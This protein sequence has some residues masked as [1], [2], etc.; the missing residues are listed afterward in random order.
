MERT[1]AWTLALVAGTLGVALG[2]APATPTYT[3]IDAKIARVQQAWAAP[4]ATPDPNAPGWNGLFDV[5]RKELVAYTNAKTE[6]DGL[7]ALGRL[8]QIS[9][10]LNATAWAPAAEIRNELRAWLRPRVALAW[11]SRQLV[12]SVNGLPAASDAGAQGNRERWVQFVGSDLGNALRDYE[13]ASEV[14]NRRAALGR[15]QAA[16]N[17]LQANNQSSPWGPSIQLQTALN[18]LFNA[19][20]LQATADAAVVSPRLANYVV[21]SG[22][23]TRNGQTAY[24]TAGPFLGFGLMASDDGIMFYNRQALSSVTPINGFQQQV[25]RDP[26]GQRAAK[27]YQ[28]GATST[29]QSVLTVIAVLRPSGIQLFPQSTHNTNA[30]VGSSP[31]PGKGFPR[32]IASLIG[33]N[34]YKITQK[35]HEGAIG[36]IRQQVDQG[37]REEA[38]ERTAVR[39]AQTNAQ[40]RNVFVGPNTLAVKDFEVDALRLRSRPE[41]VIVDGL[42]KWRGGPNQ[43]GA[44]SPRPSQFLAAN[45]G[46]STDV[47]LPSVATNLAAGYFTTPQ[48]QGVTNVMVQTKDVPP[49]TPPAQ[50]AQVTQ[51]ADFPTFSKAVQDAQAANNPKVQALRLR[52]PGRAPEFSSDRDGNL[53]ALVY[54]FALEVPAPP[55]SA[56]GG[57][58][59][60]PAKIYR[61]EAPNAEFIVSLKMSPDPAGGPAR[62]VARVENFDPGPGNRVI[63]INDNEDQGVPMNGLAANFAFL[64]FANR[65]R[66]QSFDAPI[67]RLKL[68]GFALSTVSPIDPTG[69]MRVVLTPVSNAGPGL[70]TSPAEPTAPAVTTATPAAV[71]RD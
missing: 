68:P 59:T 14:R 17:S 64:A 18:D 45:S 4:G 48:L 33:L 61:F 40:L 15:V 39:A 30:T 47:H 54:D 1:Y 2:A 5:V 9:N 41:F 70:N 43:A 69:W 51:N 36:Q 10:A 26:Q 46:V 35:V 50:A 27:L 53:V 34:Q 23:I 62:L 63:A 71:R 67:D 42:V 60:P 65:L 21:E 13:G 32:A 12:Q 66:G 24:V 37:S 49:G 25:S 44:D 11:A 29:D 38:A 58:G 55:G 6:D 16:L 52:R 56:K 8:Y 31:Q 28:F 22:P 57:F 19:P 7:R 20:N 3:S